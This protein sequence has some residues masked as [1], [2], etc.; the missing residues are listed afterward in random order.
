MVKS[1]AMERMGSISQAE[2]RRHILAAYVQLVPP[3]QD[4]ME[5]FARDLL[6]IRPE[7]GTAKPVT[8]QT[9]TGRFTFNPATRSVFSTDSPNGRHISPMP[10]KVLSLLIDNLNEF[11]TYEKLRREVWPHKADVSQGTMRKQVEYIRKA[12]G[13]GH[14]ERKHNLGYRI[15]GTI[16]EQG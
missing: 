9:E 5:T 13:E 16:I 15:R 10:A 11:V 3:G 2:V 4:L 12:L 6:R 14:I 7:E 1:Q 8:V